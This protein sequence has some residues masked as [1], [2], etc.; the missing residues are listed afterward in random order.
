[1]E[2]QQRGKQGLLEQLKAYVRLR[3]RLALL[4]TVEKI[5]EFYAELVTNLILAICLVMAFL[6]G[7]L[8]LAFYLAEVMHSTWCG[9]S[10]V[11]G[12][13][14]LLALVVQLIRKK[15]I[16]KPLMDKTV[17]KIFAERREEY[18]K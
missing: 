12:I 4:V 17:K 2:E 6:F 16:E 11:A 5:A 15:T 18:G 1:M 8:A 9:F 10:C 13:Y 3:M 14:L 7:S